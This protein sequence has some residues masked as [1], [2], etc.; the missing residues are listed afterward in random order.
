MAPA[1]GA[2][3]LPTVCPASLIQGF[4]DSV[5]TVTQEA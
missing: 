4:A 3:Q 1:T 2:E 5:E